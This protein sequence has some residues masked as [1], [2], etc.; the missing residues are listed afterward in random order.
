MFQVHAVV[1]YPTKHYYL[2]K[3]R[4]MNIRSVYFL[5]IL[6]LPMAAC[7]KQE[8]PESDVKMSNEA[9]QQTLAL[10]DDLPTVKN[11]IIYKVT[12]RATL[13]GYGQ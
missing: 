7:E 5:F 12:K 10:V 13:P 11:Y 4:N 9:A 1:Q 3:F 6:S 2:F 8:S